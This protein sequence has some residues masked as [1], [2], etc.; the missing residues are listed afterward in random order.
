M[1]N[2][3]P[4]N[5]RAAPLDEGFVGNLQQFADELVSRLYAESTDSIAFFAAGSVA[6]TSNVGPWWKNDEEWYKWDTVTGAYV[7]QSIGQAALKWI[8]S[9]SAPDQT[10]YTFWIELDGA[11]KAID[12]KYYSGG[13]WKDIYEDKFATYSTTAQMNAAIAAAIG[14]Q[15]TYAALAFGATTPYAQSIPVDAAYHK[16]ELDGVHFDPSGVFNIAASRFVAPAAGVYHL[17][18]GTQFDND[19]GT[20]ATMEVIISLY[21]NGIA[22]GEGIGDADSTPSPNGSR[23]TPQF[24]GLITLAQNDFLEVWVVASDGVNSGNINMS[25]LDFSIYRVSS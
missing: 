21:K 25:A 13:A 6:P 12:I 19:T 4:L 11:G 16:L 2:Q 15:Q 8:A 5:F 22:S 7:P 23:W 9:A 3:I 17:D 14:G 1:A 10:I 24:S 20:A 18:V